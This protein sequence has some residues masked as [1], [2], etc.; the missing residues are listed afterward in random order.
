II[1]A[2]RDLMRASRGALAVRWK[3]DGFL[4]PDR[5]RPGSRETGRNLL[6][7]KDGISNPSGDEL[8]RV[9]WHPDGSTTAVVRIIRNRVEFWDRVSLTEQETMIGRYKASGAPLSG[10]E[11][12]SPI[13]YASDP[14]GHVI[15]LDAHIRLANPRTTATEGQRILRRGFN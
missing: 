8:H 6:G 2:L 7:F 4:P 1:H 14:H 13:N 9:V 11:E 3:A 5:S 15:P 12:R 10:G